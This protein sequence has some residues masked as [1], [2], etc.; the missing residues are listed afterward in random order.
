[1]S[2]NPDVIRN[3]VECALLAAG[4]P[5]STDRLL[6]LFDDG[7]GV[8]RAVL[9]ETIARL[10]SEYEDRGLELKEVASGWRIQVR[11]QL[12]PWVSRLWE[13]RAPKYSRALLETLALIA[14]QQPVTRGDIEQVR[15][16]SVSSNII[17]TLL[18]R[19]WIRIVGHRD[20]PGK[21][22]LYG[23][24][25][26]FLDY[27]NLRSLD[28][29]PPLAELRDLNKINE[30][31]G[32]DGESPSAAGTE[33]DQETAPEVVPLRAVL[34]QFDEEDGAEP[35]GEA[36]SEQNSVDGEVA[37]GR[38]GTQAATEVAGDAAGNAAGDGA[39]VADEDASDA[40]MPSLDEGDAPTSAARDDEDGRGRIA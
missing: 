35:A 2:N 8:D 30:E 32:F 39:A 28:K 36:P 10:E 11:E 25:K 40:P 12:S 19:D 24:T 21:P 4:E 23:T 7:D 9:K 18:E 26:G 1:M 14:Y 15:G 13:A 3:V 29:L 34:G 6:M 5:V 38:P 31:L 22:V 27:F 16:V 17:K 20:V 37:E 33:G